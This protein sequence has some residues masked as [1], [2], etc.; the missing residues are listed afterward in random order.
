M[1]RT[2][3][4]LTEPVAN[5]LAREARRRSVS[6]SQ[7]VRESLSETLGLGDAGADEV[8]HDAVGAPLREPPIVRWIFVVIVWPYRSGV[9]PC[10]VNQC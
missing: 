8:L 4:S 9:V 5:A 7:V 1:Q 6:A 10:S 3:V 2:T